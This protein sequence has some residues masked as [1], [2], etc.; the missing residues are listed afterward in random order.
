MN[1]RI[2]IIGC[3]ASGK[4]TLCNTLKT[5]G[6]NVIYEPFLQNPFLLKFF[7]GES[8]GFEL[9]MCFLLQHYNIIQSECVASQN[10]CDFSFAL[11]SI[12]ASILLNE[13][14]KRIYYSLYN[15]LISKI[16]KPDCL[17]KLTCPDSN[18]IERMHKRNREYERKVDVD[19]LKELNKHV[20]EFTASDNLVEI[21]SSKIDITNADILKKHLSHII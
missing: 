17:I 6:W 15:H 3:S 7:S 14:E 16:N 8:C 11:D 9:Q 13:Q 4:T 21:D 18:I 12:Y 10:I 20:M 19:F 2:E 5:L 1:K